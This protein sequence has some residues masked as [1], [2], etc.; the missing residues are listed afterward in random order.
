MCNDFL[1]LDLG[2]EIR[3]TTVISD[4]TDVYNITSDSRSHQQGVISLKVP[5]SAS[6]SDV[7]LTFDKNV[8]EIKVRNSKSV[9]CNGNVCSFTYKSNEPLRNGQ[10]FEVLL[11][12]GLESASHTQIIGYE[13]NSEKICGI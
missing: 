13:F 8:N 1:L 11:W 5:T 7:K 10:T 9:T 6:E 4:C 3:T 2:T 12:I